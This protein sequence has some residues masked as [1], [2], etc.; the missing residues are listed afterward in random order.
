MIYDWAYSAFNTVVTTFVFATYFVQA[1]AG[2]A[3]RGTSQ[4]AGTQAAAGLVIAV[5]AAPLGAIADSGGLRRPL[6]TFFTLAMVACTAALWLVRPARSDVP[7]ALVLVGAATVAYE[8][9]TTFYNAMLPELAAP[10][11]MGRLSGLAWGAGYVGGLICLVGCLALLIK[12]EPALFGL[13]RGQ[14]EHVRAAPVFAAAWMLVFSI[15]LLLLAP[16]SR[17]GAGLRGAARRGMAAL[18]VT[19]RHARGSP[20]LARFL[21]ARM[22]YADGLTTLFAFGAIYAAGRFGMDTAQVLQL[23]IGLTATA[24]AGALVFAMVEDRIGSRT[25]V[26]ICLACLTVLGACVL[27]AQDQRTFL[28]VALPLGLFLGPAQSASRSMMAQL[29]PPAER[30]AMFGLYALSGRVTGFVG[31]AALGAVTALAGSQEAGMAVIIALLA[32]GGALLATVQVSAPARLA[33][34][35]T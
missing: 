8:L 33:R 20:T 22:L 14:A 1:V 10:G 4:W 31:P 21:L 18:G 17:G 6:L 12:P 11:R 24:G 15:P 23:G 13:D 26:L 35:S 7:L 16:S 2:D 32:G 27:F 9:A 3:A 34:T 28:Y 25:T 5:C 19:L 30:N 29:A